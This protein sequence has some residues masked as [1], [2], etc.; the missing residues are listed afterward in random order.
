M[1]KRLPDYRNDLESLSPFSNIQLV[2]LDLDGT[3]LESSES[4]FPETIFDLARSLKHHKHNVMMTIATGRTLAGA[5]PL[6]ERLPISKKIP[7]ILYNGSIVL[8]GNYEVLCQKTISNKSF[9]QIIK[10]SSI[11]DVKVIAYVCDANILSGINPKESALGWSS[12]DQPELEYNMMPVEWFSWDNVED[13]ITPSAIV[14]H[15]VGQ[16]EASSAICSE[17]RKMCDISF[18]LGGNSYIEVS[19]ADCNKGIA[20]EFVANSLQL[21]R[22]QIL[23]MGDNDNDASMLSWAGIG[24]A[25][26][27]ASNLAIKNCNYIAKGVI[28]G[29]IEVLRLVRSAKHLMSQ[30]RKTIFF[31]DKELFF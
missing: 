8:T 28:E 12:L 21:S 24:V 9:Q 4:P 6:L 10:I 19:P 1:T 15:T 20:V 27:S 31:L 30:K 26:E 29:A 22:T 7:I 3:I 23:A 11:F 2:V 13:D 16:V 17:L 18:T 25:V 14:I 5:K